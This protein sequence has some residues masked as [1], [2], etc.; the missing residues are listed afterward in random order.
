M[1]TRILIGKLIENVITDLQTVLLTTVKNRPFTN[2]DK[3]SILPYL[4]IN[5]NVIIVR[6]RYYLCG[7]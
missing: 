1:Q 6:V 2:P 3:T 5:N 7:V 4:K